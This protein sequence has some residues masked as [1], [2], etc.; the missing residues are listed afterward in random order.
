[1]LDDLFGFRL[2]AVPSAATAKV[3]EGE[4]TPAIAACSAKAS[5]GGGET[6]PRISSALSA[7]V[8]FTGGEPVSDAPI[9][10]E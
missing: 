3:G 7:K 1:M 6:P 9:R 2:L 8:G 4:P 10:L 5:T